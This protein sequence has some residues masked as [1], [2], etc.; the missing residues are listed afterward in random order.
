MSLELEQARRAN[1]V[2][3][4]RLLFYAQ[5]VTSLEVKLA[6][7]QGELQN[8]RPALTSTSTTTTSSGSY[9]MF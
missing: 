3:H 7:A 1:A 8:G 5:Q 9:S 4:K 2:Q 6:N